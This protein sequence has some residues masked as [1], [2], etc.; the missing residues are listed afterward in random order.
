M[1]GSI[2]ASFANIL[3]EPGLSVKRHPSQVF[4]GGATSFLSSNVIL[5]S[6]WRLKNWRG[7]RER[8]LINS[9]FH[10]KTLQAV[11]VSL[12]DA[13]KLLS[14]QRQRTN[15]RLP[16]LHRIVLAWKGKDEIS[17]HKMARMLAFQKTNS[18]NQVPVWGRQKVRAFLTET[19]TAQS[20]CVAQHCSFVHFQ[21]TLSSTIQ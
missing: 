4:F 19:K 16:M 7:L 21:T 6:W 3:C 10:S 8:G 9:K 2:Y 11:V 12:L 1:T 17:A 18:A 5:L 20:N 14:N 15:V 13:W